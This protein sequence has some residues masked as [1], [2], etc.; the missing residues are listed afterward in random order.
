MFMNPA[1]YPFLAELEKEY[2][3][4]RKEMDSLSPRSFTEWPQ[5]FLYESGWNVFGLYAYGKKLSQN[6]SLCPHTTQAV[7]K[8]PG[9]FIAGFSWLDAGTHIK[10]HVG[11][12][13]VVP[14]G[15]VIRVGNESQSWQEG[16]TLVFDDTTEHEVWNRSSGTR[17]VL[18]LD[19][20]R[21]GQE[22][23]VELQPP[24]WVTQRMS[25]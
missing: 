12:T 9:L 14:E 24:D 2:L 22:Q 18:L 25:A 20:R 15:C 13:A 19:F 11:Y 16:K 6:C 1:D 10:P 3:P 21:P 17:V 5:K 7:E 23:D 8:I 4:I